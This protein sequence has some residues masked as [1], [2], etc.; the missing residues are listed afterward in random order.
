M[1]FNSLTFL[2]FAAAF[3]ALWPLAR[4]MKSRYLLITVGSYIFYA[5]WNTPFLLL[6]FFSTTVDYWA[7]RLMPRA[8]TQR[9]RNALLAMSLGYNLTVLFFFKYANLFLDTSRSIF[10]LL[11][12]DVALP[13]SKIVLPIGISFYTFVTLSY[14]IDVWRGQIK[15]ERSFLKYAAF[16]SY[17]PHLVAGPILRAH[18]LLP[19]LAKRRRFTWQIFY[20]GLF[21]VSFGFFMKMVIA[22][23]LAKYVERVYNYPFAPTTSDAWVATYAYA[24]QIFSDFSGYSSIAIGLAL[25]MGFLIPQNFNAPY[26]A[27]SFTDFW[28]RWHISLSTWFRDYLFLPVAY[29]SGRR[30]TKLNLSPHTESLAIYGTGTMVTMLLCGLWHGAAWNFVAWGGLHGLFLT[31]ERIFGLDKI[32]RK[33]RPWYAILIRRLVVFQ[34]VCVSW[35]LFRANFERAW[36]LLK[37]MA[38]FAKPD[39]QDLYGVSVKVSILVLLVV[40]L[41]VQHWFAGKTLIGAA[42]AVRLSRLGYVALVTLMLLLVVLARGVQSAFIYFQF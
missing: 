33:G 28:T 42:K 23:N 4:N 12:I 22:D 3:F 38:G 17:W 36:Q 37:A 21:L 2:V 16:V 18:Q 7:G 5:S 19:Q 6:L 31:L 40:V 15:P 9:G 11:G 13:M 14:T 39:A 8:K 32:R 20:Q 26:A 25:W 34:L 24:M 35:V 29:A 30:I 27:T 41:A 1:L 10:H